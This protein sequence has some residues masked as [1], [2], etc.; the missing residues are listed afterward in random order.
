MTNEPALELISRMQTLLTKTTKVPYGYNSLEEWR[1]TVE[2][3]IKF[4]KQKKK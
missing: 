3:K 2:V 1:K 4:I